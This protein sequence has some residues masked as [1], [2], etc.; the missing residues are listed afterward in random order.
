MGLVG[1]GRYVA[2][3]PHS[4]IVG[5]T[6]GIAVTIALSQ[7]G[8]VL[9]LKAKLGYGFLDKCRGI[10]ANL[11]EINVFAL[12][13]AGGTFLMIKYLL[14]VSIL[15]PRPSDRDRRGHAALAPPC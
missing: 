8:E 7:A 10:L 13:L 14:K 15:H 4:I 5:F 12:L 11:R 9:G 2:L 3:V 1:F 6:I